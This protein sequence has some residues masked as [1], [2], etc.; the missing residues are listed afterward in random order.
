MSNP[1]LAVFE[2]LRELRAFKRQHLHFLK[3]VEDYD[4]VSEI[5]YR[6]ALGSPLTLNEALRLD[7][8]SIATVQRQLRRLRHAG[9]IVPQRHDGDKRV[10][11]ITLTT[12]GMKAWAGYA[13]MLGLS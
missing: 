5:A 11:V 9:V 8:G 3:T 2:R 6:Q 1:L 10:M 13:E 12:K 4:L 7:L